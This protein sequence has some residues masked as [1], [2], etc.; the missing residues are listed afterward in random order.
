[1][2]TLDAVMTQFLSIF[3]T[4]NQGYKTFLDQQKYAEHFD[5]RS[6]LHSTALEEFLFYLFRDLVATFGQHALLGKS[7]SFKDVFFIPPNYQEMLKR[8]YV[9]IER[10]DYDLVIGVAVAAQFGIMSGLEM[11]STPPAHSTE[12]SATQPEKISFDIPAV[13]IECKTYL[14]KT[15]LEGASL[16][17]EE[18]KARNP[19][20]LYIIVMEWLKLTENINLRKYKVDQMYVLR[21]QRNTDR[22]LRY[23]ADYQKKPI[24]PQ[25][26]YHL[27]TQV[28]DHL[29]L[30]WESGIRYGIERGWLL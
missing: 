16:S 22:E 28:R 29:T 12:S 26:V 18:L 17:A 5:S 1:V 2:E 27:F 15:M 19:N 23:E 4:G 14:D 24:D 10:K 11:E 20:A 9:R 7:H 21:K 30:D 25:V 8:P 13:V 6:N 3:E